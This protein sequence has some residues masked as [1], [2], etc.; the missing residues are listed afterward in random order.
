MRPKNIFK[1]FFIFFLVLGSVAQAF[2]AD[3]VLERAK[4]FLAQ[5]NPNAAYELLVPLQSQ[6]AGEAEYDY[7]LGIAALDSG[8]ATEAVFALERVL[9]V[10]PDHAQA[11][12]EIAR[13]YFVLGEMRTAKGEFES[14]QKQDVPPE[15]RA[16]INRFLAA[17]EEAS[18]EKTRVSGFVE[19]TFG[20]DSNVNSA[21]GDRNVAIPAFGG[22]IFTLDQ[23]GTEASADFATLAAGVNVRH[24][25]KPGVT[26]IAGADVNQ[27]LHDT[28]QQFETKGFGGN[29]G[30]NIT[31]KK[32]SFTLALQ[33]SEFYV[34]HGRNRDAW[35]AV[36]QWLRT[37]DDNNSVSAFVQWTRL[38]YPGQEIRNADRAVLGASWARAFDVKY[39]PVLFLSAYVGE[40]DER[41]S[42]VPHLGHE[43]WGLRAGGQMTVSEK[44]VLFASASF[45]QRDY[46]GPD[47][48]FLRT[49]DDTQKDFR[50]GFTYRPAH[51]WQVT[52]QIS[53]T[54]TSSNIA[55]NDFER[56][57]VSVTVRREF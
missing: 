25:L 5:K 46:G 33:G 32:D 38:E 55:I 44:A 52:P 37:L 10:N 1:L 22:L 54:D 51:Q 47:P 17:I 48:L 41:A 40:E 45:E 42:A 2:A 11:R 30:L 15:A 39:A 49:R 31:E 53:Y 24:P 36:G 8:K 14:V 23:A 21:T 13:A 9:A 7:L 20:H 4:R 43:L 18:A 29:V 6:R 27:R 50:L 34:D 56:T 57:V 28:F 26:L 19:A 35:G 3:E 16:T 12:A